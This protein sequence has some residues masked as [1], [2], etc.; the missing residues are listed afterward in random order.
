MSYQ[1]IDAATAHNLIT[2]KNARVID[3]RDA[4]SFANG[5]IEHAKH[6]NDENI[7]QF[8]QDADFNQIVIVCCYHGNMSQGAAEYF[9]EQGFEQS[10][11]LDGGYS[12]WVNFQPTPE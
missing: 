2:Q 5:H 11:S 6:I 8:M 9:S 12:R 4:N 3:I 1:R 10:Y 7:S